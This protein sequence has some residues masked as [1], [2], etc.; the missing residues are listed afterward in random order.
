[1]EEKNIGAENTDA[2]VK[3][4]KAL[5]RLTA[6]NEWIEVIAVSVMLVLIIF[7]FFGRLTTVDGDSMYPTLHNGE[8]LI[9]SDLF[10]TPDRGDI[11]VLQEQNGF[12]KTPLVKRIIATGGDTVE[13]D[14]ENWA[15]YV[16]GERLDEDYINREIGLSMKNYGCT[17][18]VTVPKGYVFVM[19]DNRNHSTDSRDSLVGFVAEDDIMGEV[20]MRILPLSRAGKP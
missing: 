4:K 1:M 10:Y 17:D 6:V 20:V 3:E 11:V 14:F 18:S 8:R 12:F 9:V 16:N 13:F 19:G 7:T 5:R 15:V 2:A